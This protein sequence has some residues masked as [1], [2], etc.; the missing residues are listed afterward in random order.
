M[1]ARLLGLIERW[2]HDFIFSDGCR[3]RFFARLKDGVTDS[4]LLAPLTARVFTMLTADSR[5][6]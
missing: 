6:P 4:P 3:H 1:L 2:R 5:A